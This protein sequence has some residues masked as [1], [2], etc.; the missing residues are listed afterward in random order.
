MPLDTVNDIRSMDAAG[1]SRSEIA[2]MLHV[3][4]NT[5]AKYA[6]MED[7]SPAAPM[8]RR[9]GRPALEGN[10]EWV[11]GV[12]EA[13]LGAPRK[14]RHTA[15]RIYDRLVAERGYGGSYS[16]V[17]RFVRELRLARAAAGGEGYL[18]LEWAPGTCQVDFGNFR[19][20]VGGRTLDL[21]LLVATLPH[22]ND[23]Q[24]VALMSQ[25]SECLCAGLLEIFRR[26]GRAPAAMVLDNATEAGRMVR[27]EVTESRLFSQFRAHYRFESRYCNPYSGNEKGSVENAV[28]FLRRNLLVPVP[29]FGA[30]PELNAF[31][32]EGCARVNAAARCRDGRPHG[33]AY[34][35]DLAA[36]RALPGVEFDA[37]RWVTARADKRGYVEADGREYVAG[38]AWHGRS[39]LVG[40]R[41]STVE[42]LADRG[43][44]VAVLPRA[45]GEGPAV[46][47]PLSL[48][49]AIIARPRA[50]GESTIRRDMPPGLVEGID[51]M[52]SAGRRRTLRSIGRASESSGFEAACEAALRVVEGGRVPDDATVDVW[53]GYTDVDSSGRGARDGRAVY[54]GPQ[55]PEA[56]HRRFQEADSRPLQR[57][58][59]Q[60]RDHG[61]VR[62]R[63]EHRGEVDQVDKRDR[64]AARRGQP[65]ARAEP[66]PGARAREPQAPDGG[67]R[68]KTSGADIRSKVRAIAAN[69]GRYPI[70]AQC[71]LLG[72]ARSTYYSMRSRADRP[73]APDPA[74]PAVVAAH[75]ASKG[76][77]GSRKIKASLERS[78]V[79]VSR[80]RVCRIMRENGLV[81][82]YGRKRFKVHP[83]A[84]NEADVPN[85]VARGFGGR[86][87]RTHIC[88]DLTYV[89]VGASWNYVCLL[90]D[91]YNREIVGHSAG[92]R[93]DARLVKSAFATLSFPISDIEVFHTDRG[94]EFDNAEIDLMLEAFGIE[95][96]LSAKGCPYDNAVDESTNRILKAELVHRETFSTTRE[97]RA[98]LSDYVHW[99]N[100]FR[101]HST[102]GY[103]S[104]VEFREAG[105][106]LPESSK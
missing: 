62:P 79:T 83:G 45:F 44:R 19:A 17:Q 76:R 18:E 74:T 73:A 51:R 59:A 106:S 27:G 37:V 94:S 66:D 85:V 32:A 97:L 35:E 61:R 63:Q 13:D 20:A 11:A 22:S 84:V 82:A 89:R 33:E 91:L 28:G 64:L 56:F 26:W 16:T 96:S 30:L 69:E 101:I 14:Q 24:C 36:M 50:F 12:L 6:D 104:P 71:R 95:R 1:R 55:A 10:E 75:A 81:S 86:A 53:I 8:P 93:K 102:L 4:R 103:M 38:P 3:S 105:L 77:Y 47:N 57:R 9:R 100:N 78:G 90:V 88:S 99:Y 39:L 58:Q 25:R 54:E 34:R 21:K 70:S 92:P 98:K 31:L 60:T 52:D 2:R 7:M 29:A 23:R 48:V 67:R 41:A 65:H 5:V 72:V 80:R 43:R 42:I 87:P 15:R 46:R 49:P 40:M 68:L